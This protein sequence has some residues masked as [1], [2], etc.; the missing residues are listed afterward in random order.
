M[1]AKASDL[2]NQSQGHSNRA[3]Q[4]RSERESA[5]ANNEDSS[6][7][8]SAKEVAKNK[9]YFVA[10]S[11][12]AGASTDNELVADRINDAEEAIDK[13][14]GIITGSGDKKGSIAKDDKTTIASRLNKISDSINGLAGT[15]SDQTDGE[16]A[17]DEEL[18]ITTDSDTEKATTAGTETTIAN[19]LK[20]GIA[21]INGLLGGEREKVG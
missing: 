5:Q 15:K 6:D 9:G 14:L 11:G 18:G 3:E 4:I 12:T 21:E 2:S 20:D 10:D 16:K 19:K 17:T 8:D 7:P 13:K 1:L